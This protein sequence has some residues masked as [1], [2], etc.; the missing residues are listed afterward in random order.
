MRPGLAAVHLLQRHDVGVEVSD[1][2]GERS[3]STRSSAGDRPCGTS[4]VARRTTRAVPAAGR[5]PTSARPH[6]PV[7]PSG[8]SPRRVRRTRQLPEAPLP[9]VDLNADLGESYGTWVLGDDAA[10]LP[11]VTSANVACGFH[12]GDPSTLRRT[13]EAAAASGVAVGAQVGYPDLVG[14]GRRFLD[15]APDELTDAVLYQV[16]A[17]DALARVAGTRV[18][19]VKPHGALYHAVVAHEAQAAAVV[20]ALV[21]LGGDLPLLGLPGSARPAPGRAGGGAPG[22]R[23]LRR[24]GLHRRRRAAVAPRAGRGAARPAEV[25]RRVVRMVGAREVVAVDG[26]VVTVE[27]DSV[28]VHGD[29]PGAVAMARAVRAALRDE[30]V[31]LSSFVRPP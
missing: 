18:A 24:P 27:V 14:F 26:S 10:L 31:T 3:R 15:M 30:G 17:L 16:G 29:S 12:A 9:A 25:A 1:G 2:G 4:E 19:Y 6:A 21:E 23:G 22:P 13:C 5:C 28:C 8:C 7:T 11:L 20:R